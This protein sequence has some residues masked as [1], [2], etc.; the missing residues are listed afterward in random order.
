M[1][2][3]QSIVALEAPSD[4]RESSE[5]PSDSTEEVEKSPDEERR[6]WWRTLFGASQSRRI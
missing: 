4:P 6:S 1:S 2:L 3:S 5:A